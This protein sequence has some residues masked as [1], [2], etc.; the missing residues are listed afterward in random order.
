M[1]NIIKKVKRGYKKENIFD[2]YIDVKEVEK[3][4]DEIIGWFH[5]SYPSNANQKSLARQEIQF[6]Q[7]KINSYTNKISISKK[8]KDLQIN[9]FGNMDA[10]TTIFLSNPILK[11]TFRN[12]NKKELMGAHDSKGILQCRNITSPFIDENCFY[13]L[14][15]SEFTIKYLLNDSKQRMHVD[16]DE[17]GIFHFKIMM[18]VKMCDEP[19]IRV[20][21]IID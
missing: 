10:S 20:I 2:K 6:F 5:V 3:I 1:G 7:E 8:L 19:S 12:S 18:S 13:I 9:D 4:N 14:D 16:E 21:K 17:S 11:N 15:V